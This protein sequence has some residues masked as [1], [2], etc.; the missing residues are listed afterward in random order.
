MEATLGELFGAKIPSAEAQPNFRRDLD[1]LYI[2]AI[3]T[4]QPH[5]L[6]V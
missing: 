6:S 4:A 3:K 5:E 2:Q 1:V